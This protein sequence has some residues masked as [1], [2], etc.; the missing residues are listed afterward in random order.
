MQKSIV[1][2][3]RNLCIISY[4]YFAYALSLSVRILY[5]TYKQIKHPNHFSVVFISC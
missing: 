4:Q 2:N 1:F 5:A 3:F